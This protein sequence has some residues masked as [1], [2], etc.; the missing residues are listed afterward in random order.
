VPTIEAGALT[1]AEL[2][3]NGGRAPHPKVSSLGTLRPQR[4]LTTEESASLK[5]ELGIDSFFGASHSMRPDGERHTHSFR[6]QATFV[7]DAVDQEGMVVGFR[8]VSD[9]LEVEAKKYVS[10]YINEIP[11]FDRI[12]PTGENI[13]AVVFRNLQQ[14]LATELA[15]G[16]R[17]VSV[18]LWESPTSYVKVM[19]K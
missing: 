16:P 6:V 15:Y 9:L 5:F 12:Q 3:M 4:A 7:T 8:E 10:R 1:L 17:L 18:T 14:G 13:A 11:P 2:A 19:A